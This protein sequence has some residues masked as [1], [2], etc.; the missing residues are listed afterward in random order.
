MRQSKQVSG[1]NGAPNGDDV[2]WRDGSGGARRGERAAGEGK[3][4]G[5]RAAARTLSGLLAASG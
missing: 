3:R 4:G 2:R 5:R 1:A